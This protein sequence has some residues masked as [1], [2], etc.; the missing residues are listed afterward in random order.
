MD[1]LRPEGAARGLLGLCPGLRDVNAAINLVKALGVETLPCGCLIGRYREVVTG[2]VL[3]YV[4]EKGPA[5]GVPAHRRNHAIVAEPPAAP[6][7]AAFW[8]RVS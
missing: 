3:T 7:V 8:R 4:E 5:C 6:A 1:T 2:R